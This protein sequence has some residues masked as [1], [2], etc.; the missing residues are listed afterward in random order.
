MGVGVSTT[1]RPPLPPGKTRYPLYRRLGGPQGRSGRAEN[2]VPTGIR[3][4]TV[5]PVV[6]HYTDWATLPTKVYFMLT[7]TTNGPYLEAALSNAYPLTHTTSSSI[8]MIIL[9]FTLRFSNNLCQSWNIRRRSKKTAGLGS[10]HCKGREV[11]TELP[12]ENVNKSI[13]C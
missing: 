6:S 7:N 10:K 12:S 11:H 3:S 4:R 9:L 13:T 5:Q 2:F 8:S 1:P